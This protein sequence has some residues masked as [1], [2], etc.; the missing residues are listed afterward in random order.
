MRS[1][2]HAAAV[3]AVG[4]ALM[5]PVAFG[6]GAK[7]E[8]GCAGMYPDKKG[9]VDYANL[10]LTG[11]WFTHLGGKTFA[12]MRVANLDRSMPTQ[13]GATGVNWYVLWTWDGAQRF[14]QA[15]VELGAS[16]EPQYTSGTVV[17]T[18]NGYLRQGG[19]DTTGQ[20]IEGPDGVISIEIVEELGGAKGQNLT[21]TLS[22]TKYSVGVPGVASSLQPV[23]EAGGKAYPVGACDGG[24]APAPGTPAPQPQPKPAD[25]NPTPAP[26]REV[27]AGKLDAAVSKKLPKAKKIKKSLTMKLT[28][29][30]GISNVDAALFKGTISKNKVVG[31]GKLASAKGKAKLKLKVKKLKKGSYTLYL[32][33]KNADGTIADKT[34]K[35]KLK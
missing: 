3:L 1:I 24:A 17:E 10:D 27:A 34:I 33:G 35:L 4:G 7:P 23:D 32:V 6:Q 29:K 22:D 31:R 30:G 2:F 12:N 8:P 18:P 5:V 16:D 26:G 19:V 25:T 14:V 11:F 9:D 15:Q 28:S 21:G 13:D 20:F